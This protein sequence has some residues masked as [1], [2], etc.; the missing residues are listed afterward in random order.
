MGG[1]LARDPA[2]AAIASAQHGVVSR[3]QLLTLGLTGR[4][5]DRRVAAARLHVLHRGVYAVGHRVLTREA[6]WLAAV[7]A[8]GDAAVLSHASAAVAWEMLA[9]DGAIH[10]TIASVAGRARRAGIRLHRST[11]LTPADTTTHREIPITTPLRTLLDVAATLDGR[12]L[13]Q[14]VDRAERHID[15]A[16][17][18]R[19]LTAHPTR[20]GSP[21]LQAVLS[22]YTV[23]S[24][25]TRSELE[26]RFLRLCDDHWLPR[27]ETNTRI[28]GLEVDFVWRDARLIVEVDGYAFHRSPAAFE[29]DR[30]RDVRLGLA[31]W[32][33]LRFTHA[34]IMR[35]AGWIASAVRA[36]LAS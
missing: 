4:E 28:E 20:P 27:P 31:G 29:A 14:V 33:V 10:V 15:F 18:Q 24:I 3:S 12:R 23:G 21:S 34:A 7:L 19:T 5:I 9:A 2:I 30:E 11:T 26:E 13:E 25:V 16:E 17:L 8:C 35:R 6:R 36:H 32:R 22:Q 1:Q